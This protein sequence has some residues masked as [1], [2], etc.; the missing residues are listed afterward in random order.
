MKPI[1]YPAWWE[2]AGV[3][4]K[5]QWLLDCH[6]ARSYPQACAMLASHRRRKRPTVPAYQA[7]LEKRGLA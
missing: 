7:S 4:A 3:D 1:A 6:H 2:G 5:I